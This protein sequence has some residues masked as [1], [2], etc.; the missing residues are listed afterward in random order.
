MYIKMLN[1][2]LRRKFYLFVT[3]LRLLL[4]KQPQLAHPHLHPFIV[5]SHNRTSLQQLHLRVGI[6][7][8]LLNLFDRVAS[9]LGDSK[10]YCQELRKMDPSAL[11]LA[12]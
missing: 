11:I 5:Y 12:I 7:E 9:R 8:N 6:M 10:E 2:A 3:C 1:L 4:I